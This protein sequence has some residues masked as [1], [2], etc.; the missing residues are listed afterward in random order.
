MVFENGVDWAF[1]NPT[2][3]LF[4]HPKTNNLVKEEFFWQLAME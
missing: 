2:I 1:R 4:A 3:P